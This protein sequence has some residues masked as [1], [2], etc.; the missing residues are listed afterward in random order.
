MS[1][2]TSVRQQAPATVL[3]HLHEKRPAIQAA[4]LLAVHEVKADATAHDADYDE[5]LRTTTAAVIA[6]SLRYLAGSSDGLIPAEAVA[7]VQRAVQRGVS[8]ETVLMRYIAAHGQFSEFTMSAVNEVDLPSLRELARRQDDLLQALT[9][10]VA[11][12]YRLEQQRQRKSV[13]QRRLEVIRNLLAGRRLDTD[14]NYGFDNTWHTGLIA[15]GD[16]GGISRTLTAIASSH[17]CRL[18]SVS[19][20]SE[21][22][23]AW[24]GRGKESNIE[25]HQ[26]D[27]GDGVVSIAAGESASG[28]DGWRL[29]HHEAQAA[30]HVALH[31]G[32]GVI[33]YADVLLDAAVLRD[34]TVSRALMRA[35]LAPLDT[36]RISGDVARNTLKTYLRCQLNITKTASALGVTRKTVENRLREIEKS[37]GRRLSGCLAELEVALRLE[38]KKGPQCR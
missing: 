3:E 19:L 21:T 13:N 7:Q 28:L 14:L 1:A 11:Q 16:S 10:A 4:V 32:A 30:R 17:N 27:L 6:Y 29:T 23:W 2:S 38:A 35:F 22:V 31:R 18:L 8:I 34:E 20:G 9:S 25:I 5:G 24:L 36:L 15:T 33:R 26:R 12:E 37:L